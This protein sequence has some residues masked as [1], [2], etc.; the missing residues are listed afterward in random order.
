SQAVSGDAVE[1]VGRLRAAREEF[2]LSQIICWFDQGTMLPRQEVER[3]M[4]QLAERVMP[5]PMSLA[6]SSRRPHPARHGISFHARTSSRLL[7]AGTAFFAN[8]LVL[9]KLVEN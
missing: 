7:R 2:A 4:R 9:S 1:V 3:A 6:G 5:K 8:S